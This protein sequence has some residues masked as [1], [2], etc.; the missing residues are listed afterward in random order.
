MLGA[1]SPVPD[2]HLRELHLKI[3]PPDDADTKSR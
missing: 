3:E 1:P 2:A